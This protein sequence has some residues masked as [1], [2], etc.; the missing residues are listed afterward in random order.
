MLGVGWR[1]GDSSGDSGDSV[2]NPDAGVL[3][4]G[5]FLFF[6]EKDLE[7]NRGL[8]CRPGDLGTQ[9]WGWS[10]TKEELLGPKVA[11]LMCVFF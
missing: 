9:I 4:R 1:W 7:G 2:E 11:A 10:S 6:I 8:S 5:H 3:S